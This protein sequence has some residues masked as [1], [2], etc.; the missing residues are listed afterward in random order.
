MEITR[1]ERCGVS[2]YA[3]PD[4]AW[5]GA[6]H[7]FSTRLG[8][9]SEGYLS[10]LNLGFHRGDAPENIRENYRRFRA[11][12]ATD[13]GRI[14]TTNQ[15]HGDLVRPVTGADAK[16]DLLDECFVEADGLVTDE[17]GLTLT[18]F[19]A[20]CVPI[21]LHDPVRGVVAAVHAGWR[22]TAA[23]IAGRAVEVMAGRYGCRPGDI[24]AAIGPAIGGCCFE[25]DGDVPEAMERSLGALAGPFIEDVG[26]GRYRVELKGI[27]REILVSAGLS[28]ELIDVSPDCTCC[29]HERYWSHRYTK[30]ERGSQAAVIMLEG[31]I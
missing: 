23:V 19:S 2:F 11:A 10:S 5:A 17:P 7:G 29:L 13:V 16:N 8:G 12:T 4:P 18:V 31:R 1:Q 6:A 26:Q 20:D 27:N 30:G 3:C 24:R 22:G 28:R 9:V 15:V 21:L 25:T 14:V